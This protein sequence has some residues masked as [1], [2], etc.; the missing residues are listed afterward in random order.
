MKIVAECRDSARLACLLTLDFN[1]A[2]SYDSSKVEVKEFTFNR[3]P[4]R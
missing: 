1:P 3:C 4:Y 2:T